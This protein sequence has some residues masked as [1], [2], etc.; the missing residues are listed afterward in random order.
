MKTNVSHRYRLLKLKHTCP[1]FQCDEKKKNWS[2]TDDEKKNTVLKIKNKSMKSECKYELIFMVAYIYINCSSSVVFWRHTIFFL[3]YKYTCLLWF[4][5]LTLVSLLTP[6]DLYADNQWHAGRQIGHKILY[7]F[8]TFDWHIRMLYFKKWCI[9]VERPVRTCLHML[10]LSDWC[11]SSVSG[12]A[13]IRHFRHYRS[14]DQ[15]VNQ[16]KFMPILKLSTNHTIEK[17]EAPPHALTVWPVR[18]CNVK[19]GEKKHFVC[20]WF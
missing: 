7:I 18:R 12:C 5:F 6:S 15:E 8:I 19:H 20:F 17:Q 9:R 16:Y 2:K 1:Q 3:F 14:Q 10:Q 13:L 11:S 4:W